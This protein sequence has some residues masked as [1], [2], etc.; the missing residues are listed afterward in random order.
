VGLIR[1]ILALAV[2]LNHSKPIHGYFVI[3]SNAAVTLFFMISG[4]YM[5][6]VMTEKYTGPNRI[7]GFY[8]NRILRLYPMYLISVALMLGVQSYLH[9]RT[10]GD[11]TSA[12]QGDYAMLPWSAKLPLLLPNIALV[13]S[14][15]PWMFHYGRKSG[16]HFSLGPGSRD[17][18]DAVRTGQ[19]LLIPPAWSIG[20][21]LWFYLLVP[22]LVVWRTRSLVVLALISLAV[23]LALEWNAPWSSYFFFPANLCFFVWGMLAYRIYRSKSY[24]KVATQRRVNLVF[25]VVAMAIIFR[26][27]IPFYRNYDWGLYLLLGVTLPCLFQASKH[28]TLDRWIGNLS[29]PIYLIHASVILFLTV[30]Y[31]INNGS[32]A[33]LFST[34]VALLFLIVVEQPLE[35]F[36]QRRATRMLSHF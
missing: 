23:R 2:V 1:L 15:I 13:G 19:Y 20:F 36:R 8:S 28:W 26:Q 7:R 35:H 30:G 10:R 12:W 27:C 31:R 21:E 33:V 6:L 32:I 16:W 24:V 5:A 11:Y 9:H 17:A 25:L 22:F 34:I 3:P 14:D 4:F 29:Y 18:P